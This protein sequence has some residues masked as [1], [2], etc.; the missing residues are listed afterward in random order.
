IALYAATQRDAASAAARAV[1]VAGFALMYLTLWAAT[2]FP[3]Y[4]A[5]LALMAVAP[6]TL[7]YVTAAV[8]FTAGVFQLSP[9]K[10]VCLRHCRSPLGFLMG[11]W[12][13]GPRGGLGLGLAHAC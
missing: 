13:A 12:R 9:L 3:I 8:L 4:F 1:A 5:I 2:G 7:A 10:Q 6:A 11:H